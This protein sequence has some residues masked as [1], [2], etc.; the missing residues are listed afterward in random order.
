[1]YNQSYT[2]FNATPIFSSI[3]KTCQTEKQ[4]RLELFTL[5]IVQ[6]FLFLIKIKGD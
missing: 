5:D 2:L 1:M 6:L 4:F 3:A